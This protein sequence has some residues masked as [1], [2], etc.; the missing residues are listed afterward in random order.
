MEPVYPQRLRTLNA[1]AVIFASSFFVW[2]AFFST[3]LMLAFMA[4]AISD[5]SSMGARTGILISLSCGL[6]S[7][8]LVF[9][10]RRNYHDEEDGLVI[11]NNVVKVIYRNKKPAFLADQCLYFLGVTRIEEYKNV[12]L[13]LTPQK[14]YFSY[15]DG[16]YLTLEGVRVTLGRS[17]D[18]EAR[19][20]IR[21]LNNYLNI[22]KNEFNE[23]GIA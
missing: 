17:N 19:V 16:D 6:A 11:K 22:R 2:T 21:S 3:A 23:S 12:M 18:S 4:K 9:W 20:F 15:L 5:P 14:H 1:H 7:C 8:A 13:K 10:S